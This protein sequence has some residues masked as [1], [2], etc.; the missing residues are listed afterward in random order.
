MSGGSPLFPDANGV[1]GG[2]YKY[3]FAAER[4]A[5]RNSRAQHL[6]VAAVDFQ[7]FACAAIDLLADHGAE[8][9][10]VSCRC[11]VDRQLD[12]FRPERIKSGA[13]GR[14]SCPTQRAGASDATA[15]VAL[16]QVGLSNELR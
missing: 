15:H 10:G 1:Y 3:V 16:Q 13:V 7:Q 9:H 14:G 12:G 5:R 2:K 8:A 11:A 4:P 6:T